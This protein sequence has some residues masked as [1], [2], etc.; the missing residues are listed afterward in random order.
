[1]LS[2]PP[3]PA[4][5]V[6]VGEASRPR[7]PRLSLSK[8][9]C[10][11]P[12][13]P[14]APPP[15]N[16]FLLYRCRNLNRERA[17]RILFYCGSGLLEQGKESALYFLSAPAF[18]CPFPAPPLLSLL[19]VWCRAVIKA[20]STAALSRLRLGLRLDPATLRRLQ[21]FRPFWSFFRQIRS[22]LLPRLPSIA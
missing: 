7:R 5:E 8:F 12:S 19:V 15:L 20:R 13:S 1:V 9:I 14:S 18:F 3:R 16:C 21:F 17:R 11:F 4:G 6:S 10:H 22:S 2:S